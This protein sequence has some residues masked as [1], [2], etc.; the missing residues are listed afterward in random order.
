MTT[1][2][3]VPRKASGLPY[4]LAKEPGRTALHVSNNLPC[5]RCK[6]WLR[7]SSLFLQRELDCI[8]FGGIAPRHVKLSH[9]YPMV[10]LAWF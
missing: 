6:S 5:E 4:Q 1:F 2:M 7:E 9:E 8:Q 10:P 3:E